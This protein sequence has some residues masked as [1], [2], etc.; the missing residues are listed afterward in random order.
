MGVI[1]MKD[2]DMIIQMAKENN[3]VV[4]AAM[5]TKFGIS[6]GNLKYLVDNGRLEKSGRGVYTFPDVWDDEL[7]SLQNR[8]KRG[9]YSGET[10][11]FLWDLSDRTPNCY[12]MTFPYSYNLSNVK[13]EKIKCITNVE[14]LY[15]I[16]VTESKIPSGNFSKL[17]NCERTL[18]DILRKGSRTDIQIISEAF[19]RYAKMPEKNI[20]LLSKY[21]VIFKVE[22]KVRSYLEVLL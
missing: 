8:F 12:S 3:G 22:K 4:T 20:P 2:T 18:C 5:V 11:L 6:R 15:N 17:Y 19:K 10:A 14:S 1:F 16:G 7:F 9:I 21:A 13:T